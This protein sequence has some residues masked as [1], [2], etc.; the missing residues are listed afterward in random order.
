MRCRKN[1]HSHFNPEESILTSLQINGVI[2]IPPFR[3][4][5]QSPELVKSFLDHN[6]LPEQN[7]LRFYFNNVNPRSDAMHCVIS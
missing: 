4:E 5:K 2:A 6:F 7:I 3:R 1:H